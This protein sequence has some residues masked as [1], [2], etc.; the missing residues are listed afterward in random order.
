M[1]SYLRTTILFVLVFTNVFAQLITEHELLTKN[2]WKAGESFDVIS[3]IICYYKLKKVKPGSITD[4]AVDTLRSGS[5]FTLLGVKEV[6]EKD[7]ITDKMVNRPVFV[8][9]KENGDVR[10][11]SNPNQIIKSCVKEGEDPKPQKVYAFLKYL[12]SWQESS[13]WTSFL[14]S[15]IISF[16][17]IKLFRKLDS[18]LHKAAKTEQKIFFPGKS[19][20]II[21]GTIGA[22]TG[23]LLFVTA[24]QFYQFFMYAPTFAFPSDK[25]WIFQY[26]WA[27]QFLPIPFFGFAVYRNIQEFGT[28]FGLIRSLILLIAGIAFFW[29]GVTISL[30]AIGL[31]IFMLMAKVASE[32][33]I[34]QKREYIKTEKD[35]FGGKERQILVKVDDEGKQK[36]LEL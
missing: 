31:F 2:N 36:R 4:L 9:K 33:P 23:I 30:I 10:E 5:K 6:K 16:L 19:F 12:L 17:F 26:Y 13:F 28:N 35:L 32:M 34:S 18:A 11:I 21:S 24:D 8:I 14:I 25:S 1:K 15:A 20:F 22:I 29:T 7:F 27:I 3:E